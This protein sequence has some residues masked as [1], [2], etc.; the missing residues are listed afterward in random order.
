MERL[1]RQ[2]ERNTKPEQSTQETENERFCPECESA[3]LSKSA[4][5]DEL[6]CEDCGLILE[7]DTIDHHSLSL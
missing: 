2:R 1:T 4:D 5:Q 6:I 7:E 3:T